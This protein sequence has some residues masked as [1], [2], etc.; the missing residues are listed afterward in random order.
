MRDSEVYAYVYNVADLVAPIPNFN[1][2][3]STG[4]PDAIAA[5][6]EAVGYGG[7]NIGGQGYRSPLGLSQQQQQV[8]PPNSPV[9]AQMMNNGLPLPGRS[10]G[11]GSRQLVNAG[12]SGLGGAAQADFEPLIELIRTTIAPTSWDEVGGP[13]AIHEFE[14]TLSLVISQTQDVHDQIADLLL[15]LRKL[16]DLQ[17]TIEVRFITLSDN[18]FERIGLDFDFEIDDNTGLDLAG[19]VTRNE[20]ASSSITVGLDPSGNPT[21][22]LDLSFTQDGFGAAVP[23]FGGFDAATAANFGFAILSDIEAF[24][25]IQAAQGDS[26]TNVLQAPKVTL[27]NGQQASI[28]D[29]AQQP[30]VT[31]IIPVVGDFAAAQQPVITV[32]SEGTTLSVQAVVSPDRRFVRLTLVPFFSQIGDV[33]TFT[34]QGR[35]S[36]N[37]G[38]S[39]ADP[40]D[41]TQ[42]IQNGAETVTEG[43]TVQLP[44]FIFTTVTTTVSVPDGGT[45]LL[46]GIKRVREGRT[47]RGVPML[48]KLPYINRLFKNVGIG[49]E[50][51]SLMLMVTPR[52]IIQD[53]EE[54]LLLGGTG[55]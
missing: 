5:A 42:S 13:G 48:D 45:V 51:E 43:T 29:Q 30:F 38:T 27:F 40:T 32:L 37:T 34:F 10:I 53:E 6:H 54:Q 50:A 8:P 28:Q 52:I 24:F 47:E 21:A 4:L 46:G 31:G 25:L 17:V 1:P 11:G 15:Q 2:S 18:F 55:P 19:L 3:H 20:D 39:A 26:R 9:L 7:G 44:E 36:S 23:A 41:D 33:Q 35:T 12:P 14:G 16:Q 22:D 49:R